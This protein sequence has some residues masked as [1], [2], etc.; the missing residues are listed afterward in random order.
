LID[1]NT[2]NGSATNDGFNWMG[3]N[4]NFAGAPGELRAYWTPTGQI[5]EGDVNGDKKADFSI[6]LVDPNH[7]I[8]LMATDFDL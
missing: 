8:T 3:T 4:K 2:A 5:I 7:T 6:E 1:A